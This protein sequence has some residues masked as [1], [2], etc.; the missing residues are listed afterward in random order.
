[1]RREGKNNSEIARILDVRRPT[2]VHWAGKD[3]YGDNRGWEKG[4]RRKYTTREIDRIVSLKK[5]R[6]DEKKYFL[7]TPYIRMDYEKQFDTEPLPS[8]WFFD[9]VIRA[10]HLQTHAPKRKSNGQNIVSR[11]K[12]PIQSIIR[13][14]RI[15]Q[16]A[17]FIGKKYIHGSRKP[18]SI[19]AT[20]FYQWFELYQIQQ[21]LAEKS[22]YAIDCLVEFWKKFPI[23][24][25]LRTD[26][27]STFRGAVGEEACIGRFIIFLLNLNIVP[28]FSAAYQSYTNPHIEGH[29]RTFT[30][31]L[32]ATQTFLNT[33]EI[34]RECAR[35][36]AESREYFEYRFKER[37]TDK[38]LRRLT[39]TD[40]INSAGL[41]SIRGKKVCFIRF[42]E[43]WS[44]S[45]NRTGFVILNRFVPVADPYLNQYVFAI[46]D[47]GTALLTV[48]SEHNGST[49]IIL[50]KPFPYSLF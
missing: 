4:N 9:E 31:K 36:N 33:S 29:N 39:G 47:L 43:R 37:L 5:K 21:V 34:D 24:N 30:D 16:S 49:T 23:A 18:I 10:N 40:N 12:F 1:L 25:V 15:Q 41:R 28:L 6:V 7:G 38:N 45:D 44:E 46:L 20:S 26:N 8:K 35:F 3:S 27:G 32:W 11:L 19:F 17:D 14:G 13:L 42:V 48:I 22:E 50:Q 2:I